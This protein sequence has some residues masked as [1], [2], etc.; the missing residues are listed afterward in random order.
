MS[1]SVSVTHSHDEKLLLKESS[2]QLTSL[3]DLISTHRILSLYPSTLVIS[4]QK[5]GTFKTKE[6]VKIE[7][8]W[9]SNG[10]SPEF[11]FIIGWPLTNYLIHFNIPHEKEEWFSLLTTTIG[12]KLKQASTTII[13]SILVPNRK[14]NIRK[15]ID[16]GKKAGEII[17]ETQKEL[18][19]SSSANYE[20]RVQIGENAPKLL[21]NGP[22]NVYCVIMHELDRTGMRLS[23]SH[24]ASLDT[25]PI[26]PVRLL[27]SLQ[28]T[29]RPSPQQML[30]SLKRRLSRS[31]SKS[32]FGGSLDGRTPPQPILSIIDHL[33]M[34]SYD[35]E[36]LFRKS[37]KVSTARELR[38]ELERGIVPD[39]NKYNAHV[40]AATL[41]EYLRFIPN[42]LLLNGNYEK[43][44]RDVVDETD[45]ETQLSSAFSLLHL[46]PIAHSTLLANLLKL[47]SK[48]AST[49][50][51]LMTSSS[52]AVCLAPS[53]LDCDDAASS[54]KVPDLI[55][56]L[57]D[58]AEK[59]VL[60][61]SPSSLTI[62]EVDINSNDVST[63]SWISSPLISPSVLSPPPTMNE[64]S[65]VHSTISSLPL[66]SPSSHSSSDLLDTPPTSSTHIFRSKALRDSCNPI[67][68]KKETTPRSPCLK[69]IHFN[70]HLLKGGIPSR[71]SLVFSDSDSETEQLST[72][73]LARSTVDVPRKTSLDS[74]RNDLIRSE[75]SFNQRRI[76]E[77][78]KKTIDEK[79]E[80]KSEVKPEVV[81]D[82]D[83]EDA[84]PPAPPP[85]IPAPEPAIEKRSLRHR[86][87][88]GKDDKPTVQVMPFRTIVKEKEE[89]EDEMKEYKQVSRSHSHRSIDDRNP[90][91]SEIHRT[92]SVLR[93]RS[94][95]V[96]TLKTDP[97][98]VQLE[99]LEINWSVA[100]LKRRFQDGQKHP[101]INTHIGE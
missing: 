75:A 89:S 90:H 37:P 1:R 9:I 97:I 17:V 68:D 43:W 77:E 22:E 81:D 33:R 54:K 46:L 29:S 71:P 6:K 2:V 10:S 3:T 79:P 70:A 65:L 55:T 16:N 52:L 78:K 88:K 87:S 49:P 93:E 12:A 34:Y 19:L 36:G 48:V 91:R 76:E 44:M 18:S 101:E 11:S 95:R 83:D 56:F 20:M 26:I 80:I 92:S 62:S 98:C 28:R 51:S 58:N 14:Q 94:R 86:P 73:P 15:R 40:L 7:N 53:F 23:E 25:S 4:K 21:L 32:V 82:V 45:K 84:P 85:S 27:L 35:V 96:S 61:I 74:V 64:A 69:R 5:G 39:Y 42:K 31:E 47:L 41:K 63:P 59:I 67:R 100:Q 13:M 38:Q 30:S 66:P 50:D 57:I 99:S 72:R 24:R 60:S 8:V